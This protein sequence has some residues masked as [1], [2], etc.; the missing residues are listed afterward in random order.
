MWETQETQIQFGLGR[1][2]GGGNGNPLQ[3]SCLE[4]PMDRGIL[5]AT[6]H[7][8]QIQLS[9]WACTHANV[10]IA[11]WHIQSAMWKQVISTFSEF[12]FIYFRLFTPS[13]AALRLSLVSASRGYSCSPLVAGCHSGGFPC[14]K[15][16]ALGAQASVVG[17]LR[18]SCPASC[19]IFMDLGSNLRVVTVILILLLLLC[20][21]DNFQCYMN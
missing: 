11:I 6:I 8:S 14:C 20:E 9:K 18:L 10:I 5:R 21:K 2:P 17:A 16:W 15:A 4:N 3:Y 12:L 19:G 1:S 7:V 13:N